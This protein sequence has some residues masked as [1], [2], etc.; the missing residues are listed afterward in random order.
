MLNV[1]PTRYISMNVI[2]K[3]IYYQKVIAV[4]KIK[5][6]KS[7]GCS[8]WRISDAANGHNGFKITLSVHYKNYPHKVA[9]TM[10]VEVILKECKLSN[11]VP[12]WN[13]IV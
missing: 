3:W 12:Q 6:P 13:N 5:F 2:L 4:L 7:L 9:I 1:H 10:R 8:V 11:H